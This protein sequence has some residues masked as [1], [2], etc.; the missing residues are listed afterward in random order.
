VWGFYDVHTL[1]HDAIAKLNFY[2][3]KY[4]DGQNYLQTINYR[5]TCEPGGGEMGMTLLGPVNGFDKA[6]LQTNISRF[7]D[8]HPTGWS[9]V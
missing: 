5:I 2:A 1:R 7:G 3:S 6:A 8:S 4:V 9:S